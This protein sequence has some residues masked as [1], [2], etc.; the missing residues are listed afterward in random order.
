MST[1][2]IRLPEDVSSELTRFISE[3]IDEDHLRAVPA[4][5]SLVVR[6]GINTDDAAAIDRALTHRI[7]V[8]IMFGA[9]KF[10]PPDL[11]R[12]F[13]ELYIEA[14]SE[15]MRRLRRNLECGVPTVRTS[16][17]DPQ[18]PLAGIQPNTQ[19]WYLGPHPLV[20]RR[21]VA[22]ELIFRDSGGRETLLAL[23]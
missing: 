10:W 11:V 18:L 6:D 13:T 15:S 8:R 23:G 7:P 21:V 12:P 16:E 20:E 17:F 3:R 4:E 14:Y 19:W 5:F 2:L 9:V 22:R 1:L